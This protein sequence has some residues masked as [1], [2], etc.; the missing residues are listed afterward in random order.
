VLA[1][2]SGGAFG[3]GTHATTR[4]LL[5]AVAELARPGTRVL[6]VGTGSGILALSAARLGAEAVGVDP[7]PSAIACAERNRRAN[8]LGQGV[9]FVL[10]D[11]GVVADRFDLV[12]ANLFGPTLIELASLLADRLEP[13]GTLLVSGALLQ[14]V[15]RVERAFVRQNLTLIRRAAR[16]GWAL[17]GFGRR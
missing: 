12:L 14:D 4:L 9:R 1:I 15:S 16:A 13:D 11:A 3:S 17:L 2:E 7:D 5:E 8:G 10:G 6:D